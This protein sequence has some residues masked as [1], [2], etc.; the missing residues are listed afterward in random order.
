MEE[1]RKFPRHDVDRPAKIIIPGGEQLPVRIT[2]ES[3]GGAKLRVKWIGW[4]PKGFDLEDV[5]T[6]AR[7]AVQ[8]VWSQFSSM[9]VRYRNRVPTQEHQ[10]DFGHRGKD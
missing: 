4:L 2:N 10:H 6:G 1:R 8:T 9:G 7:R 5:F 3:E